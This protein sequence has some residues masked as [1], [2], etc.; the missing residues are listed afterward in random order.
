M[1]WP[2]WQMTHIIS[3]GFPFLS[4]KAQHYCDYS[5]CEAL[6]PRLT[7]A[8]KVETVRGWC[9]GSKA[10]SFVLVRER[11]LKESGRTVFRNEHLFRDPG[12]L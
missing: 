10:K 2:H 8:A 4:E 5:I 11:Q 3:T 1:Q 6:V 9:I 7:K 12:P